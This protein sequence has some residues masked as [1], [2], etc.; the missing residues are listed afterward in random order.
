FL[1]NSVLDFFATL[2]VALTAVFIGFSLLGELSIGPEI[3]LQQGLW[4]LLTVPLL[5]SEMKKLGQVYHQK[6]QAEAAKTELAPLFSCFAQNLDCSAVNA[7]NTATSHYHLSEPGV[8]LT[9]NNLKVYDIN[10]G[11][12]HS[13]S[14]CATTDVDEPSVLLHAESLE[15][16]K[17]DK[18]LISGR[19]GSGKTLL[20]EALGGQ[21]S[22]TH[23]FSEPVVWITQ[24]P[25]IT[26]GTVR[27]NLC[28]NDTYTDDALMK[29]L[30]AVELDL[31]LSLLPLGLDTEMT[32][33]PLL[34][35][36]EAQ[37]LSL[38]RA[39]LRKDNIWLL[40]EPTAHLP[41]AQHTRL[42]QLIERLG[43]DKT[44]IWASH[45]ALP[46]NWFNRFWTVSRSTP[47]QDAISNSKSK[48]EAGLKSKIGAL[49]DE[50]LQGCSS[51]TATSF[52]TNANQ[53]ERSL[54]E[55]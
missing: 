54:D 1:S 22:S 9:A 5:L 19:S 53:K 31:W 41:D 50:H 8:L 13:Q 42:A 27:E 28:L 51:V 26:S 25:V 16:S 7:V 3:T 15:V 4:I 52:K 24:H 36:G 10:A 45:K 35:G 21:R 38:A 17:G 40:D 18:I 6:A 32:D 30:E 44:L 11:Q 12:T 33:Y 23:T 37:R 39:L 34:S 48:S 55:K 49:Q 46:A 14:S 29:A 47:E 20:L 43:K 2:A